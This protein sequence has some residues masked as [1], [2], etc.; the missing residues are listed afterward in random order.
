MFKGKAIYNPSGK[1][2]EYSEWA[3]N[4][5][6]GCSGDCSYCYCK[7]YPMSQFW[8]TTP[9]LKKSL[10]NEKTAIKI[11]EKELIKNLPELQKHGLF[12]NF[13]SD[14]FLPEA[15]LLTIKALDLCSKNNVHAKLLTK[16]VQWSRDNHALVHRIFQNNH[17]IGFTLTGHD[18]LEPGCAKNVQRLNDMA[19]LNGY[20]I[21]TWAS[22]E[23]I[24]DM[25]SSSRMIGKA[26]GICDHFKIGL[27]SGK[28][29]DPVEVRQWI[30]FTNQFIGDTATIYWKDSIIKLSG[31]NRN[32]LPS[33]CVSRDYNLFE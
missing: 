14:P 12:F 25:K 6:N 5:F 8:S 4:F 7:Q 15:I 20:G 3:V 30:N 2:G 9:T 28:K 11:F 16:Q 29:F 23:P 19:Y 27:E 10:I 13:S 24:I 32:E 22:I 31:M 1:A 33:N 17:A 21:K 18:E 26:K